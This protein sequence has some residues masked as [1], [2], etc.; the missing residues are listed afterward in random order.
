MHKVKNTS[1][2]H[3]VKIQ[4][5][6]GCSRHYYGDAVSR[7]APPR[8][9]FDFYTAIAVTAFL[10]EGRAEISHMAEVIWQFETS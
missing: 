8:K 6:R 9:P 1:K 4:I 3:E 10:G 7:Y 2:I 5:L